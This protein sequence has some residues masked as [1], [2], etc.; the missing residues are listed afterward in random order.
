[1]LV[2]GEI[3]IAFCGA[4]CMYA[5]NMNSRDGEN[6]M[7]AECICSGNADLVGLTFVDED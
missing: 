2:W 4:L 7:D 5:S 6:C 3:L 1:M